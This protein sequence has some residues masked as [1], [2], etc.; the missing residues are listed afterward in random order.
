MRTSFDGRMS[1]TDAA[2]MKANLMELHFAL[3]VLALMLIL[4]GAIPDEERKKNFTCNMLIN[5]CIRQKND[6][7]VFANPLTFDQINKNVLPVMSVLS[8]TQNLVNSIKNEFSDDD[9]K[10]GKSL[11]KAAKMIP[12]LSQGVRVYQYGEKQIAQ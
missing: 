8:D 2:N 12:G 6:I 11:L 7:M 1:E 4:R 10:H 5:M 9:K 3:G